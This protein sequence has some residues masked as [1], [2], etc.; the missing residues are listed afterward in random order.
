MAARMDPPKDFDT[1]IR[2]AH[3]LAAEDP[4]GW[5]FLL[6]GDGSDRQAL[7]AR[8]AGLPAAGTIVFPEGGIEVVGHLLASDVGLLMSDP[9]ILAEG[10]PNSIMEYM[11][12]GLP[13]VCA[14]SGGCGEITRDGETGF[15]V[16]PRDPAALAARLAWLRAHP[17]ERERMGAAGRAR[18]AEEF[19]TGRFIARYVDL[20]D[21]LATRG[22][23]L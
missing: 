12:C 19:P 18:V 15:V 3:L 7:L 1:V 9:A 13:V 23:S 16:P 4:Q 11:A 20:Y 10:C 6:V 14:D 5:R 2:T 21:E 17:Q 22:R 8:A